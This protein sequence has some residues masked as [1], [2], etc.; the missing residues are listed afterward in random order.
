VF[1]INIPV[2]LVSLALT[3]RYLSDPPHV[4]QARDRVAPVDWVGLALIAVGLM[5][6]ELALERGQELEWFDSTWV[7][8]HGDA[9]RWPK[10]R[11]MWCPW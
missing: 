10:R 1:L 5:A 3:D 9:R 4:R 8:L 2:G 7:R 6:F 11:E